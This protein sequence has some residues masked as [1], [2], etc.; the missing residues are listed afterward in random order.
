MMIM[1][2]SSIDF[3]IADFSKSFVILNVIQQN[4]TLMWYHSNKRHVFQELSV[5]AHHR[6]TLLQEVSM[7]KSLQS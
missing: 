5:L 3:G 1:K 2:M 6:V 7:G 4:A